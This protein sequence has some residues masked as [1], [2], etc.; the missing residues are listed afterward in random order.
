M[1]LVVVTARA[2]R[3]P[4]LDLFVGRVPARLDR[5]LEVQGLAG[6]RMI[7]VHGD[8]V[9]GDAGDEERD[10]PALIVTRN[11]LHARGEVGVFWEEVAWNFLGFAD[12]GS[13]SL[14]GRHGCLDR[15]AF[16]HALELLLET[17][18]DVPGTVKVEERAP[19][20]GLIDDFSLVV[21]QGV[22][23][24]YD[25]VC[26][27]FAAHGFRATMPYFGQCANLTAERGERPVIELRVDKG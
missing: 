7:R 13:V 17:G 1:G 4:V 16:G 25:L 12:P 3:V 10:L 18:N 2:V 6:Q 11:D 22:R 21:A 15:L 27:D 14:L 8:R 5:H 23:E 9:L 26:C 19:I 20:A 24:S